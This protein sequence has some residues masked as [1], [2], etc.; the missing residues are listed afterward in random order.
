MA[1]INMTSKK[2]GRNR[3][4]R[5]TVIGKPRPRFQK[6]TL[7]ERYIRS[8]IESMSIDDLVD[9]SEML[10]LKSECLSIRYNKY[11]ASAKQLL[12]RAINNNCVGKTL[13]DVNKQIVAKIRMR[14]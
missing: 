2:S 9:A 1:R 10:S 11:S 6:K 5:I 4:N 8:H 7:N 3:I 12:D 13:T 14:E